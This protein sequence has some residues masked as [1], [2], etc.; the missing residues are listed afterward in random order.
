MGDAVGRHVLY[1]VCIVEAALLATILVAVVV[2]HDLLGVA[3]SPT[4]PSDVRVR[5]VGASPRM[6]A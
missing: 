5:C 2:Q 1:A 3:P 6:K 4:V